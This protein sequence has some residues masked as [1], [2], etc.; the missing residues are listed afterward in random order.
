MSLF[1]PIYRVDECLEEI[2][3]CLEIGWTGIGFKTIRFEGEWS[4]YT[5]LPHTLFVNSA[6]AGLHLAVALLKHKG[7]WQ[8]GDEVI[9]TGQT[10]VS[11]NAAIV[12]ENLNPVF[13]AI[14]DSLNITPESVER[15]ISDRTRAIMFVGIGGNP[16]HYEAIAEIARSRG[17]SLILDAAHMAGTRLQGMQ[18]GQEADVVVFSLHAVQNLPTAVSGA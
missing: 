9:T 16:A 7:G 15:M 8:D 2:R 3:E 4:R 14:D 13:A 6:T 11:S 17:I 10:F 5:G 12:Y 18:A 1:R